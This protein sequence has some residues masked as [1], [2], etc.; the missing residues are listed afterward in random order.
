MVV[1]FER[2]T[3]LSKFIV[4]WILCSVAADGATNIKRD[5]ASE[6][7]LL[8]KEENLLKK[9]ENLL[10]KDENLLKKEM[11]LLN[12]KDVGSLSTEFQPIFPVQVDFG[13]VENTI[14][15]RISG[16]EGNVTDHG[17]Q[18]WIIKERLRKEASKLKQKLEF[19]EESKAKMEDEISRLKIELKEILKNVSREQKSMKEEISQLQERLKLVE[20]RTFL[21]IGGNEADRNNWDVD[22]EEC[23]RRGGDLHCT[24]EDFD[25]VDLKVHSNNRIIA[26]DR[27]SPESASN[28][29]KLC[30]AAFPWWAILLIVLLI[31]AILAAIVGL[32]IYMRRNR[33]KNPKNEYE[34]ENKNLS[35]NEII[36]ATGNIRS[37]RDPQEWNFFSAGYIDEIATMREEE[38]AENQSKGIHSS[39]FPTLKEAKKRAKKNKSTMKEAIGWD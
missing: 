11:D 16:I 33:E 12:T 5:F 18:L 32:T 29:G 38:E 24:K 3:I 20:N 2:G 13:S 39:S 1:T 19:S 8:K 9:D 36:G 31:L 34:N 26:L 37:K 7:N 10:K 35:E 25:F 15:Q 14:N 27:G 30:Q 21:F 4:A 22:R 17:K 6:E 28:A 23:K